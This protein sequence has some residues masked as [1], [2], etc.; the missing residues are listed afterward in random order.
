MITLHYHGTRG[1]GDSVGFW[2]T[3]I[4]TPWTIGVEIITGQEK[5]L[6]RDF[7]LDKFLFYSFMIVTDIFI[8][9]H[10]HDHEGRD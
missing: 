7:S 4:W 10:H 9:L 2:I 5:A 8:I 6:K 3:W 1:K